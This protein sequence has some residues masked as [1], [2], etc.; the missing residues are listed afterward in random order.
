MKRE[1]VENNGR[2][3]WRLSL[4]GKGHKRKRK[5]KIGRRKRIGEGD[6]L[7][8]PASIDALSTEAKNK[9]KME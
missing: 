6:T 2:M 1:R 7:I 9:E 3:Y 8:W 5:R 4:K